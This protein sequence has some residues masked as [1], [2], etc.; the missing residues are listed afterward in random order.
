MT[1]GE[2]SARPPLIPPPEPSLGGSLAPWWVWGATVLGSSLGSGG[3]GLVKA[4]PE[5]RHEAISQVTV[6]PGPPGP[7]GPTD[8]GCPAWQGPAVLNSDTS[9]SEK[10]RSGDLCSFPPGELSLWG[11]RQLGQWAGGSDGD[12]GLRAAGTGGSDGDMRVGSTSGPWTWGAGVLRA[13][14]RRRPPGPV[15]NEPSLRGSGAFGAFAQ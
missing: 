9:G 12:P 1:G 8:P 11:P 13:A 3:T 10:Q 15:L 6:W 14:S 5:G 2:R 7:S 4:Q